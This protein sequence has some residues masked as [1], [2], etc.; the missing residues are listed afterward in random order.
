MRVQRGTGIARAN[1]GESGR[2]AAVATPALLDDC[3]V[4]EESAECF[5][6]MLPSCFSL[7]LSFVRS[8]V[9]L[10]Y[11]TGLGRFFC[12]VYLRRHL[13]IRMTIPQHA[14]EQA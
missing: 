12:S 1:G 5:M 2:T 13:H 6:T 14:L 11:R 8:F 10:M 4:S 7:V 9:L 3:R